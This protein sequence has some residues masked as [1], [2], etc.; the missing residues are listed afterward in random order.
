M[1]PLTSALMLLG[2]GAIIGA[3]MMMQMKQAEKQARAI[4]NAREQARQEGIK[5]QNRAVEQGFNQR[6]QALGLGEMM[7]QPTGNDASQSGTVLTSVV[8]GNSI[9]G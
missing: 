2:P 5:N 3:P 6:R 4:R 7:R 9:L 1:N 8:G